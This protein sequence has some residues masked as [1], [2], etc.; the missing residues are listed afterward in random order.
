MADGGGRRRGGGAGAVV[1]RAG[2]TP[3]PY[4]ENGAPRTVTLLDSTSIRTSLKWV[5][6][7]LVAAFTLG[8][9]WMLVRGHTSDAVVHLDTVRVRDRGGPVYRADLGDV[10][11][12]LQAQIRDESQK[13]RGAIDALAQRPVILGRC[14]PGRSGEMLCEVPR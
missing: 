3:L 12:A 14:R 1:S 6:V 5:V 4:P 9:T 11:E 2:H 7:S 8:G 10:R 13:I